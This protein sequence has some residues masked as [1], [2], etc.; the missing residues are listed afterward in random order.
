MKK[1]L[2]FFAISGLV[3]TSSTTVAACNTIRVNREYN[4]ILSLRDLWSLSNINTI[5]LNLLDLNDVNADIQTKIQNLLIN[6]IESRINTNE[7]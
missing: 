5:S 3:A 2:L 4:G 6:L 7:L 1:M